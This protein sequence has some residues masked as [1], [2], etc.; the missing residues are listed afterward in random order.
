MSQ[1]K[2]YLHQGDSKSWPVTMT[3]SGSPSA[4][5]L[6]GVTI[7]GDI[8]TEYDTSVVASFSIT[9]TDLANGEFSF[10]IS[11]TDSASLPVTGSKTSFVFDIQLNY[12]GSPPTIKTP[13]TGYL[14]VSREVTR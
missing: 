12:G 3:Q 4:V 6:T 2:L 13:I 5:D 7:T 8:R 9:E 14:I 1:I 11:S 10:N